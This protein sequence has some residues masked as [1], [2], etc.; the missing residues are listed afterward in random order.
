LTARLPA[1]TV[2]ARLTLLFATLFALGGSLL[3]VAMC[4]IVYNGVLLRLE[5]EHGDLVGPGRGADPHWRDHMRDQIRDAAAGRLLVVSL[6]MLALL[7]AAS[8]AAG[9]YVAGRAL[10]RLRAITDAA[11]QASEATLHE[12]LNLPG[13]AD[14]LKELGDTFDAML[15]RLDH[16][17]EAQRRFVANASHELRTPLALTRTAIDVTLA[18]PHATAAQ[19]RVMG[20]DV[21]NA[22][23]RAQELI[24]GLLLLARSESDLGVREQDDLADLAVEALD[25]AGPRIRQRGL[26]VEQD[27]APAPVLGHLA[28]LG[29]AVA[30]LVENASHYNVDGGLLRVS[31]AVVRVGDV[32][33]SQLVVSNDGPL[34]PPEAVAELFEPFHRGEHSRL[35]PTGAGLGL[36]IVRAVVAAHQGTVAALANLGGGLQVTLTLPIA[37]VLLRH[38]DAGARFGS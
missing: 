16:A 11:R 2:R 12:R 34:V 20:E 13:P 17:F 24:D 14:E 22:T 4:V 21:R 5:P 3:I 29:R 36:S 35:G 15:V 33:A 28:L 6:V 26:R 32:A 37:D 23:I 8:A 27:L 31:T 10:R 30:N 25:L 1:L 18:K 38:R 7:V 9:W 19:W